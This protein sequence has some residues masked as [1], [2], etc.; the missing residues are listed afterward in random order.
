MK[1]QVG[2]RVRITGILDDPDP[3]PVGTEGTVNWLGQWTSELI[4]QVGVLWDNGSR[5]IMLP[6]DPYIVVHSAGGSSPVGG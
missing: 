4:Q 2:D 3:L 6:H 5:L 1:P